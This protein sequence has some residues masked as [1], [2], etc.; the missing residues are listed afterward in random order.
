[1]A[2][3]SI[4]ASPKAV[5]FVVAGVLQ[6]LQPTISGNSTAGPLQFGYD[7]ELHMT[8]TAG[9]SSVTLNNPAQG[10]PGFIGIASI[11]VH[12]DK[13]EVNLGITI[14]AVNTPSFCLIPSFTGGCYVSIPGLTIFPGVSCNVPVDLG[15][16]LVSTATVDAAPVITLNPGPP[17]SYAV[18]IDPLNVYLDVVNIAESVSNL[19]DL[20]VTTVL[21]PLPGWMR[22]AIE[23]VVGPLDSWIADILG[24]GH[25]VDH[26]LFNTLGAGHLW[27]LIDTEIAATIAS[28]HPLEVPD[29]VVIGSA[30][31]ALKPTRIPLAN[32]AASVN[33]G[34]LVVT[35]DLGEFQ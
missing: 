34:G 30:S 7:V 19:L 5:E 24:I 32:L 21:E 22:D 3:V 15:G 6:D 20:I 17:T 18:D 10:K 25:D 27:D 12:W 16:W 9:L 1:M 8:L 4:D 23:T 28:K 14:P 29:P 26:W 31:G 2:D 33:S 13:L 35:I 11:D